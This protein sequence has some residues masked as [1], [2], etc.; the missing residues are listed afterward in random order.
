MNLLK[1][2]DGDIQTGDSGSGIMV[3]RYIQI[4]LVSFK[5]PRISK[6]LAIYT[7]VGHYY[8]WITW[9]PG[10]LPRKMGPSYSK[11]GYGSD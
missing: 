3:R 7:D 5:N 11:T 1:S 2:P 10:C 8:D 4:G 6:S 9:L